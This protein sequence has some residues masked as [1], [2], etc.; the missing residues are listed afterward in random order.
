[1][2]NPPADLALGKVHTRPQSHLGQALLSGEQRSVGSRGSQPPA[3][4]PD[5]YQVSDTSG[6]KARSGRAQ[7][8]QLTNNIRCVA[9]VRCQS[10]CLHNYVGQ[11]DGLLRTCHGRDHLSMVNKGQ[12]ELI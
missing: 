2:L 3:L 8:G 4:T 9:D 5:G 12:K 1:M 7:G 10:S 6:L 11:S